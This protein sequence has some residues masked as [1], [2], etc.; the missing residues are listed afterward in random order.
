MTFDEFG[1]SRDTVPILLMVLLGFLF[2]I[3]AQMFYKGDQNLIS[4]EIKKE[5]AVVVGMGIGI[6][7]MFYNASIPG[8]TMV[9]DFVTVIK[10][11]FGG[12]MMGANAIGLNQLMKPNP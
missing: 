1:L 9:I 2:M 8:T 6:L 11:L 7:F 3:I 4:N 10:Y 5:L 12:F